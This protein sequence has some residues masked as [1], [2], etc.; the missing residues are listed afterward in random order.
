[1]GIVT[2]LNLTV[3]RLATKSSPEILGLLSFLE[4]LSATRLLEEVGNKNVATL[5]FSWGSTS[6]VPH[7][8]LLAISGICN[9]TIMGVQISALKTILFNSTRFATMR[10][11]DSKH[12]S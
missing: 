12:S 1:M 8:T 7:V 9:I 3:F 4:G 11:L 2:L 6:T 5:L 10:S